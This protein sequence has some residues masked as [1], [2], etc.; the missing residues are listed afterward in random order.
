MGRLSGLMRLLGAA[1]VLDISLARDLSLIETCAELA[2][3]MHRSVTA[4]LLLMQRLQTLGTF[5]ASLFT[6]W[7]AFTETHIH[8]AMQTH[9]HV[10]HT[11]PEPRVRHC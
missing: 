5:D 2:A 7:N 3:K 1:V 10:Q 9:T 8:T 11:A 6:R 4:P